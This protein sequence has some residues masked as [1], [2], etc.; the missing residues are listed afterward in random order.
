[1]TAAVKFTGRRTATPCPECKAERSAVLE[2]RGGAVASEAAVWR[3]RSCHACGARRSTVEVPV[4]LLRDLLGA[5][6]D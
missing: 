3:R 5:R 6:H 4:A 2:A 1:M